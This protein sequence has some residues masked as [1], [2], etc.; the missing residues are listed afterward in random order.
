MSKLAYKLIRV[1]QSISPE[2]L[3][4]FLALG[5]ALCCNIGSPC[6]AFAVRVV[7]WLPVESA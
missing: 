7:I 5:W 4:D 2:Y 6:S 1:P 3:D